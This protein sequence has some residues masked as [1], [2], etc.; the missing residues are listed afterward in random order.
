MGVKNS[1]RAA[2]RSARPDAPDGVMLMLMLAESI[3]RFAGPDHC[4]RNIVGA[5][6]HKLAQPE[7]PAMTAL[8]GRYDLTRTTARLRHDLAA[9]CAVCGRCPLAFTDV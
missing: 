1:L 8:A 4:G 5:V 6:R 7:G 2:P 9:H 3:V